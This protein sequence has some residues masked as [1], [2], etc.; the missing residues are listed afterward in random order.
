MSRKFLIKENMNAISWFD[1]K[2]Q[3]YFKL[4]EIT[5]VEDDADFSNINKYVLRN[6]ITEIKD[7]GKVSK[8]EKKDKDVLNLTTKQLLTSDE[9]PKIKEVIEPNLKEVVEA[10]VVEP[11]KDLPKETIKEEVVKKAPA[12]KAPAATKKSNTK[13]KKE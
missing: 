12:K 3:K 6:L 8:K 13:T 7:D 9:Q 10:K 11:K 5:T 4:G 2:S 1:P